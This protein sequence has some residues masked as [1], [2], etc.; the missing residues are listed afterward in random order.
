MST[1]RGARILVLRMFTRIL[2]YMGHISQALAKLHYIGLSSNIW[3][4]TKLLMISTS[5]RSRH[6]IRVIVRLIQIYTGL[7]PPPRS[8]PFATNGCYNRREPYEVS[9]DI[10]RS[11]LKNTIIGLVIHARYI[12]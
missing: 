3:V 4:R 8:P 1:L 5:G 11:H 10:L 6:V 2:H 12:I 7:G 9:M